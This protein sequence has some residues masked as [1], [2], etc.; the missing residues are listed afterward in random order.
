MS[1]TGQKLYV[2]IWANNWYYLSLQNNLKQVNF[3]LINK[4]NP[5]VFTDFSIFLIFSWV[6][7]YF[8]DGQKGLFFQVFPGL[9][10][11]FMSFHEN[12][13]LV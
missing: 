13:M 8:P 12:F 9:S 4:K 11:P 7:L 1:Y 6:S 2:P 3:T 10:K 5:Y